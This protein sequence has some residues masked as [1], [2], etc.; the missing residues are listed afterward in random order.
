MAPTLQIE[1][2]EL[3]CSVCVGRGPSGASDEIPIDCNEARASGGQL[4]HLNPI[5]GEISTVY[6]HCREEG[7]FGLCIPDDQEISCGQRDEILRDEGQNQL[8]HT[9]VLSKI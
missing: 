7:C 6:T 1:E 5:L 2:Y 4:D 8:Y 9:P 3:N